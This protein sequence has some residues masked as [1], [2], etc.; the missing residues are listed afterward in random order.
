M[1]LVDR[2]LP[3]VRAVLVGCGGARVDM[4]AGE[5]PAPI[6]EPIPIRVGLY[7]DPALVAYKHVEKIDQQGTWEVD[8]G[9]IQP[10]LFRTVVALRCSPT[11]S[12]LTAPPPAPS[13][14]RCS[15]RRSRR[16]R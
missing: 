10:N 9:S 6:V 4:T 15:R 11:S 7:L 2:F 5:F 13:S 8:V 14:M 3:R 12:E 1:R 16:F